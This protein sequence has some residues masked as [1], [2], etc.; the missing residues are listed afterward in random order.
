MEYTATVKF[1]G[2]IDGQE[3]VFDAGDTIGADD[4]AEMNLAEKPELAEE[5]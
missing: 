3:V 4:A 1:I 2:V 5:A